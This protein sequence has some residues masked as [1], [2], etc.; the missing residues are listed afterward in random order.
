MAAHVGFVPRH[1]RAHS[2]P[3]FSPSL[4]QFG[5]GPVAA[6]GH[7]GTRKRENEGFI[8]SESP[9]PFTGAVA[10]KFYELA[11][12]NKDAERR[13]KLLPLLPNVNE[14]YIMYREK[15]DPTLVDLLVDMHLARKLDNHQIEADPIAGAIYMRTLAEHMA[16]QRPLITDDPVFEAM[17]YSPPGERETQRDNGFLLANAIFRAVVPIDVEKVPLKDLISF[18]KDHR[19]LR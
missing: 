19:D 16:R 13:A 1:Y 6:R 17:A 12:A 9:C 8:K 5:R 3:K 7:V 18:R 11:L 14:P 15:M 4:R 10:N 2:T